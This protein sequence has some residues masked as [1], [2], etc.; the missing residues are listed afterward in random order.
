MATFYHCTSTDKKHDHSQCP[1]GNESWC[2]QQKALAAKAPKMPPHKDMK[3][4][5]TSDDE[6][7]CQ[8]VLAVYK[9][10]K[11]DELLCRCLQGKTE[12]Q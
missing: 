5:F 6:D 9:R 12:S 4:S 1:K 10:L 3:V 11:S 2:F 8:K 7:Q